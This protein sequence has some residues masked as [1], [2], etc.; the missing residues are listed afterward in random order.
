MRLFVQ[1]RFITHVLNTFSL[2][3]CPVMHMLYFLCFLSWLVLDLCYV[4]NLFLFLKSFSVLDI[5]LRAFSHGGA[6]GQKQ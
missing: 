5:K 4:T 2:S 3:F 1:Y 6:C